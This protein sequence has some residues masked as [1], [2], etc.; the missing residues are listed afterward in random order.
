MERTLS[1]YVFSWVGI[2]IKTTISG[3][4]CIFHMYDRYVRE[5]ERENLEEHAHGGIG[6]DMIWYDRVKSKERRE[7]D[8]ILYVYLWTPSKFEFSENIGIINNI[9]ATI[10]GF[11]S[12][13]SKHFNILSFFF[14]VASCKKA[15]KRH[16]YS[17]HMQL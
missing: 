7:L 14:L 12:H 13:K 5:R 6:E 17:L 11:G 15:S 2:Y 8:L 1:L 4:A 3:S 10:R 9:L 16:S